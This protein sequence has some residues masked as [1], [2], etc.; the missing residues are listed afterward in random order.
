MYDQG[1]LHFAVHVRM[2]DRK[3]FTDNHPD[4]LERLEDVM[5]IISQ[6]VAGKGLAEPLFH[7]FSET[8]EPCP[9]ENTGS[10]D[11]FPSWHVTADQV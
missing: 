8:V 10:F 5:S 11:E 6:E 4:Y 1:R 7:V 2:G 9:S 3:S